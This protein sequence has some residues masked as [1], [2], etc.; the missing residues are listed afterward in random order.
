[1]KKFN[2]L[3][4]I[5]LTILI[6]IFIIGCAMFS[7]C[8]NTISNLGYSAWTYVKYGLIEYPL[9]S[10]GNA[11]SDISNLWHV[12]N[13]NRYLNEQLAKQR[14]YQTLYQEEKNENKE[15]KELLK[16]QDDRKEKKKVNCAVVSRSFQSWNDSFTISAGKDKGIRPNMMVMN[17]QGAVGIVE[18]V[19][20]KTSIVRL[21][22]VKDLINEVSVEIALDD[23]TSIEGVL[24]SYDTE[25]QAYQVNLFDHD[26]IVSKGQLVATSGKGGKYPSGIF[27]GTVMDI[28]M[29]DDAIISTVYVKPVS[30]M[31]SFNYVTV[32]GNEEE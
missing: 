26:A 22:T 10:L 21:L 15:L 13:D 29:G 6:V 31:Q 2:R 3:Q 32:V 5:L 14:S 25:K 20:T 12:Y 11:F 16:L 17:S 9:T 7:V 18:S 28:V 23:G 4:R 1:M 24:Q 8:Q 27:V 30:N 19:Q